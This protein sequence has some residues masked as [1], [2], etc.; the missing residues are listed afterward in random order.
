[1]CRIVSLSRVDCGIVCSSTNNLQFAAYIVLRAHWRNVSRDGKPSE[2]N[3]KRNQRKVGCGFRT[4]FLHFLRVS[5]R[6][7]TAH[8]LKEV[9]FANVLC[10]PAHTIS[11]APVLGTCHKINHTDLRG[12]ISSTTIAAVWT[13]TTHTTRIEELNT[14]SRIRCAPGNCH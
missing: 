2:T 12:Q 6:L 5:M 8:H 1:M 3:S 7:V 11:S 13:A 10:V 14:S 9:E 4:P